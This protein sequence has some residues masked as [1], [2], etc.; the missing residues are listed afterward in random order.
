[1]LPR[2][3]TL[4]PPVDVYLQHPDEVQA[5]INPLSWSHRVEHENN[6]AEQ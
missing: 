3:A 2:D 4:R 5:E 6:D 1:M